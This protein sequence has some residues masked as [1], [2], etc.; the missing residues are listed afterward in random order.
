VYLVATNSGYFS[1]AIFCFICTTKSP[2]P[3]PRFARKSTGLTRNFSGKGTLQARLCFDTVVSTHLFSRLA[4][5]SHRSGKSPQS[6]SIRSYHPRTKLTV[7]DFVLAHLDYRVSRT[8]PESSTLRPET[9]LRSSP[10]SSRRD[11]GAVSVYT[12]TSCHRYARGSLMSYGLRY[13]LR[14]LTRVVSR[15]AKPFYPISLPVVPPA[16]IAGGLSVRVCE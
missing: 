7:L 1:L 9:R 10:S 3:K 13:N 5:S 12:F 8:E 14:A 2:S 16:P 11:K 4:V 6:R 15:P